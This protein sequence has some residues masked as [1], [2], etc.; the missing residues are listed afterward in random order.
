MY[1]LN[2]LLLILAL[3]VRFDQGVTET[4]CIT[5]AGEPHLLFYSIFTNASEVD[6]DVPSTLPVNASLDTVFIIHGFLS[7]ATKDWVN[8]TVSAL[9]RNQPRNIF[10]VDWRIG[11]CTE[12]SKYLILKT[13]GA[14]AENT[15]EVGQSVSRYIEKLV[16]N[17]SIL[18]KDVWIIG[19]SLGAH[20][21]GFAGKDLQLRR[22]WKLGRITGLDPAGPKFR[23]VAPADRLDKMDAA[24]VEVTHTSS[25]LGLQEPV[26][27]VDIYYNGGEFQHSC[28]L[29]TPGCSHARAIDFYI[30]AIRNSNC[31]FIGR[32]WSK[33]NGYKNMTKSGRSEDL[34][35]VVGPMAE[36]YSAQGTFYIETNNES[37]YCTGKSPTSD[38]AVIPADNS[39][40][41]ENL[42]DSPFF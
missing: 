5:S 35:T 26:G 16:D 28:L 20:V 34:M 42:F 23:E 29:R 27:H 9:L 17:Y 4:S 7:H 33:D 6:F 31:N 8:D 19:H 25:L 24:F 38:V 40:L 12:S 21:A 37:P 22:R 3:V 39:P 2:F 32:A 36:K 30:E 13:Y 41:D 10:V 14:A 1:S 11:A 15:K 18:P